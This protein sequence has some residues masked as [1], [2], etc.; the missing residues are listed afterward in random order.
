[1]K[2]GVFLEEVG[3]SGVARC[4]VSG[5]LLWAPRFRTRLN[6]RGHI[7]QPSSA[8]VP[9]N[10]QVFIQVLFEDERDAVGFLDP[11]VEYLVTIEPV[12]PVAKKT[13]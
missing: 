3:K 4:R 2:V 5:E 8:T 10:T 7:K 6:F 13:S 12:L 1:M 9:E 11:G